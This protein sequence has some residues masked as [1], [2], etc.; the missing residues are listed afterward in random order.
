MKTYKGLR[1]L[2]AALGLFL[3]AAASAQAAPNLAISP[4]G[5]Q[6]TQLQEVSG[7]PRAIDVT[8]RTGVVNRGDL[9]LAVRATL[10]SSSPRFIVL[11][12]E[13]AF[14]NVPRT[15]LIRPVISQD[16]FKLR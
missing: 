13:I 14:G 11:D 6:I 8:A 15:P 4:L 16:T 12:G 7:N 9:A 3:L 5:L 1:G 10:M 2:R